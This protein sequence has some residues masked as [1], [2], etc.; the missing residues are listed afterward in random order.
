MKK[1]RSVN[2]TLKGK[3]D[4]YRFNHLQKQFYKDI[5]NNTKSTNK[6]SFNKKKSVNID[7]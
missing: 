3:M 5:F 6:E 2:I 7:S 4:Q 1:N